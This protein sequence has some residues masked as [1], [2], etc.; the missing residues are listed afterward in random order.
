MDEQYIIKGFQIDDGTQVKYDYNSLA[1]L[2]EITPNAI[3]AAPE[4]LTAENFSDIALSGSFYLDIPDNT[5]QIWNKDEANDFYYINIQTT[6]NLEGCSLF[7][8]FAPI[9]NED[10]ALQGLNWGNVLEVK[11]DKQDENNYAFIISTIMPPSVHF[12]ILVTWFGIRKKGE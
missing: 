10:V 4:I 8:S 6:K 9:L 11:W 3:G 5:E 1:N 7:V 12:Q 2:P